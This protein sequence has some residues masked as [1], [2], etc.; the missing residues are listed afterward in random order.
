MCFGK[1][2]CIRA[3]NRVAFTCIMQSPKIEMMVTF[4]LKMVQLLRREGLKY[5]TTTYGAVYAEMALISL[6]PM[7]LAK[8]LVYQVCNCNSISKSIDL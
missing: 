6:L 3:L 8:P 5:V 7:L 2:N 4:D 1:C